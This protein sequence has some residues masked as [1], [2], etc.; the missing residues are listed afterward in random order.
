MGAITFPGFFAFLKS[1]IT[2]EGGA[3]FEK[4]FFGAASLIEFFEGWFWALECRMGFFTSGG[5]RG[6]ASR[7][8]FIEMKERISRNFLKFLFKSTELQNIKLIN[9]P[10]KII[11][12]K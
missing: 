7:E 12:N 5:V 1:F 11:K 6:A 9:Q 3:A 4:S 10:Q 2:V 8:E